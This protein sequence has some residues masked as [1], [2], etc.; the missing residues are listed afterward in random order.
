V[1]TS[2]WDATARVWRVFPTTQ[3]L[4]DDATKVIPRCLTYEQRENAFLDPEPPAWCVEMEKWPYHT[5]D[6][7]DWLRFKQANANP[8][9]PN[10]PEWEP[11]RSARN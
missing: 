10:T 8:P 9:L 7:K 4:L 5:Q 3:D 2:S 6:W 1:V 11:W